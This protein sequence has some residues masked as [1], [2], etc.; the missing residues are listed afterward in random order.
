MSA[1]VKTELLLVICGAGPLKDVSTLISQILARGWN[2]QA[3]ATSS[4]VSV[5]LDIESVQTQTGRLVVTSAAIP[6]ATLSPSIIV[7]AP[8]TANTITK[9]ALDIRDTYAAGVLGQ[10]VAAKIPIIMLPSIKKV[11]LERGIFRKHIQSLRREGVNVL[12][13]GS[14]GIHPTNASSKDGP[15]PLFPWHL[16]ASAAFSRMNAP[17]CLSKWQIDSL[18]VFKTDISLRWAVGLLAAISAAVVLGRYQK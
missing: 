2:V 16:A 14:T 12:L 18:N 17:F 15:V 3:L 10:A 13:G 6:R 8:A 7:V 1:C 9:L 4:A 5:G 11:D